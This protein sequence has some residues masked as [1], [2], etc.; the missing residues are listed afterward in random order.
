MKHGIKAGRQWCINI[1]PCF[2]IKEIST[3][4]SQIL[5]K[6]GEREDS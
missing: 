5:D 6:A 2:P 3:I 1:Q 4:L